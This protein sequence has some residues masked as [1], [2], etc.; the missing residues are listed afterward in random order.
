MSILEATHRVP[1]RS[2]V[3]AH[4]GIAAVEVEVARIGAANR[5]API[6]AAG[7]EVQQSD[8]IS[9]LV[10]PLRINEINPLLSALK[11]QNFNKP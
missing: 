3:G 10:P 9:L 8:S 2:V 6:A 11:N 5:T 4:I 1:V 7:S